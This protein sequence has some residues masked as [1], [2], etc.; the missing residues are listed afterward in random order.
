MKQKALT[1]NTINQLIL[2]IYTKKNLV[3]CLKSITARQY[4]ANDLKP[5]VKEGQT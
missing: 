3:G 1:R 2:L 4:E 5:L